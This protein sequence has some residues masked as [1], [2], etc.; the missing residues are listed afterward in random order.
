MPFFSTKQNRLPTAARNF[1]P[2]TLPLKNTAAA[3]ETTTTTETT[4]SLTTTMIIINMATSLRSRLPGPGFR[5][6]DHAELLGRRRRDQTVSSDCFL[7]TLE[8]H[9]S[10]NA[11][12]P[13]VVIALVTEGFTTRE[14]VKEALATMFDVATELAE[15]IK[16]DGGRLEAYE[17]A[18][19]LRPHIA[20]ATEDLSDSMFMRLFA[21]LM[22]ARASWWAD[23][24]LPFNVSKNISRPTTKPFHCN[25]I[26][27]SFLFPLHLQA[28]HASPD[29]EGNGAF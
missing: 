11:A 22:E 1:L 17:F 7:S 5:Y 12:K 20:W 6:P 13:Q 15:K 27:E 14:E 23:P 9:R 8:K 19:K 25:S 16:L 21:E 24:Q 4:S 26:L 28:I 3:T 29:A 2:L 18:E 10:L